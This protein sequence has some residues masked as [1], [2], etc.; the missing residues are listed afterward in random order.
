MCVC[1]C[2]CMCPEIKISV[3]VRGMENLFKSLEMH[4]WKYIMGAFCDYGIMEK[5]S[6]V[7][8]MVGGS[9]LKE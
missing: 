8:S 1:V 5:Q 9:E 2:V 6:A 3:I 4:L 7:V